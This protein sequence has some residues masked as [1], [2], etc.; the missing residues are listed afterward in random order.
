MGTGG[1]WGSA[2]A[3]TASTHTAMKFKFTTDHEAQIVGFSC[4]QA[5][6]DS[7][8]LDQRGVSAFYLYRNCGYDHSGL[9]PDGLCRRE[10]EMPWFRIDRM[11]KM[12]LSVN[13]EVG[14]D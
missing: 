2:W 9:A 13:D 12:P 6:P 1:S 4:Q 11:P 14:V 10:P 7:A 3:E 8:W 5:L